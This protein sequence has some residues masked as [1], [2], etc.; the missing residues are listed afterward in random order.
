MKRYI[1]N[2]HGEPVECPDLNTWARWMENMDARRL[3]RT[4]FDGGDVST[5]F[6][7]TDHAFTP[8][9]PVLWE[10]MVFGGPH[11][12][13]QDRYTSRRDAE[14]GHWHVLGMVMTVNNVTNAS[15]VVILP[16]P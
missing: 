3:C 8:G 4:A 14:R 15:P 6:L 13:Y 16:T 2:E 12:G 1:L 9:P 11:D 5:V 10:T 7:G